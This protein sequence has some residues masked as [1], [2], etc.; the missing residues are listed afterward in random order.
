MGVPLQTASPSSGAWARP[1]DVV[2]ALR[3]LGE[4]VQCH[5]PTQRPALALLSSAHRFTLDGPSAPTA[6]ELV[7]GAHGGGGKYGRAR[8]DTLLLRC[9]FSLKSYRRQTALF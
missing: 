3:G 2:G 5:R 8:A 6:A 4:H 1:S 9:Q 7:Q